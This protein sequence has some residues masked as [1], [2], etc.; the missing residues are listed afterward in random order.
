MSSMKTGLY[1]QV[2]LHLVLFYLFKGWSFI[3]WAELGYLAYLTYQILKSERVKGAEKWNAVIIGAG[4]SGLD[5]GIKL[6]EIGV[7]FTILEK[8]SNL[9]GTWFDNV[10]PGAACDVASHLYSLSYYLNPWWTRAYSRQEEIKA[11]LEDVAHKFGLHSYIHFNTRVEKT[12]WNDVTGK[13]TVTTST[14]KKYLA[15]FVFSASGALHI[16]NDTRFTDDEKFQGA[17]FHTANWDKSVSIKGK[18]V[19]VIGTGAS[20][21][22]CVPNIAGDVSELHVFQR[23]PAWVPPRL[24]FEYPAFLQSIFSTFPFVMR[25]HRWFYFWRGEIRFY[26]MFDVR[27][28]YLKEKVRQLFT[29]HI[30]KTVKNPETAKKLTPTYDMG[31]KRITPSDTYLQAFNLP[32]VHLISDSIDRLYE[33]GL[34]TKTKDQFGNFD[35]KSY[36]FDV[37]ILATGFN[38]LNTSTKCFTTIGNEGNVLQEEWLKEDQPKAYKCVT[39][40]QYPNLFIALGPN[41]GLGHNTVV[42]MIECQNNYALDCVRKLI[43]SGYKSMECKQEPFD[44]FYD[45]LFK[46]MKLRVFG[47]GGCTAWYNNSKGINW[48]LWPGDLSH[49]WWITSE[50]NL[51]DYYLK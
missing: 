30:N 38:L 36:E 23:T 1:Y 31:C 51:S 5:M 39:A 13:W 49:Y 20:A 3:F 11:Y 19:A 8:S 6:K 24:D 22:Q 48:T 12:E 43:Q 28:H 35:E 18:K 16:P 27:R 44:K 21:V 32:N 37:I 4:F 41:S 50:S 2:G 17:K 42:Y 46:M 10:Y 25:L 15:N 33:K 47:D 14:G 40:P 34:V 29:G 26:I 45:D 7:R 9:G